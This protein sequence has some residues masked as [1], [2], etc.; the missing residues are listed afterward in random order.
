MKLTSKSDEQ[1]A[2]EDAILSSASTTS[3][4]TSSGD[5]ALGRLTFFVTG[6]LFKAEESPWEFLCSDLKPAVYIPTPSQEEE[7]RRELQAWDTLSDEI[8]GE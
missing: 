1:V 4:Y 3:P 7:L 6:E 5:V 8:H 2:F